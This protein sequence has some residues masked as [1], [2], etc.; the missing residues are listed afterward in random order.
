MVTEGLH[1]MRETPAEAVARMT[2]A[3]PMRRL[4]EPQEVVQAMLWICSPANS[5]MTGHALAID[6]GLTAF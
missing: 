2:S 5:F 3:I 6:G 1:T 4:A